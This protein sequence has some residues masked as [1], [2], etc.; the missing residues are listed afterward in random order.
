MGARCVPDPFMCVIG[1]SQHLTLRQSPHFTE[2]PTEREVTGLRSPGWQVA[3]TGSELSPVNMCDH[4]SQRPR[5]SG[6]LT[7]TRVTCTPPAK[8]SSCGG[9]LCK[10]SSSRRTPVTCLTLG[11]GPLRVGA[12]EPRGPGFRSQVCGVV[13]AE[14]G[15]RRPAARLQGPHLQNGETSP[16][17]RGCAENGRCVQKCWLP[18][19]ASD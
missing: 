6:G 4:C 15:T 8:A 1:P 7:V 12:P 18:K 17:Q 9:A 5:V 19:I 2:E 3:E 16:A 13:R 14:A 11:R 10:G